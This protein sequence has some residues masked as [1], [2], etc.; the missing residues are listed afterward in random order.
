MGM[1]ENFGFLIVRYVP[2][3]VREE[4]V[5]IGV[6]IWARA[7]TQPPVIRFT[8]DWTRLRN[9]ANDV[10]TDMLQALEEDLSRALADAPGVDSLINLIQEAFSGNLQ[11]SSERG[12]A[13]ESMNGLA[14][15]LMTLYVNPSVK[16]QLLAFASGT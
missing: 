8:Q 7:D 12:R 9:L 15:E 1:L 4:F 10:D 13:A 11:T 5:N 3:L 16:T 6:L 2:D 14:E